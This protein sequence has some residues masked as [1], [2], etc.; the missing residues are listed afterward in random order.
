MQ[1]HKESMEPLPKETKRSELAL[2]RSLNGRWVFALNSNL[3]RDKPKIAPLIKE[4]RARSTSKAPPDIG[5][6]L[7]LFFYFLSLSLSALALVYFLDKGTQ[8]RVKVISKR[9]AASSRCLSA[10]QSGHI[11]ILCFFYD[12]FFAPLIVQRRAEC[13]DLMKTSTPLETLPKCVDFEAHFA[14]IS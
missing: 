13:L 6:S 4:T 3:L 12:P 2:F 9:D 14:M 5:V 10:D 11:R 8:G 7:S 1:T